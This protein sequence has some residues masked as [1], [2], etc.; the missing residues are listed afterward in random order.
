LLDKV[1]CDHISNPAVPRLFVFY[2]LV[3]RC[4]GT[5]SSERKR[6]PRKEG[7]SEVIE[8]KFFYRHAASSGIRT[9]RSF[10]WEGLVPMMT[11]CTGHTSTKLTQPAKL[12]T[13]LLEDK[14]LA[15]ITLKEP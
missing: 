4:S 6:K 7:G 3:L 11:T 10:L 15:R 9:E 2:I 14:Q 1:F 13:C 5:I 12:E 8:E